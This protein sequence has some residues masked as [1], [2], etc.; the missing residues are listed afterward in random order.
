MMT[1]FK[2]SNSTAKPIDTTV[3]STFTGK[4]YHEMKEANEQVVLTQNF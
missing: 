4:K 3:E 2:V 1:P